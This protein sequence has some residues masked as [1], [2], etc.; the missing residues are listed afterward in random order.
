MSDF[1][2]TALTIIGG[3]VVVGFAFKLLSGLLAILIP[4]I[5]IAAVAGGVVFILK[6][7]SSRRELNRY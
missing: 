2:K 5:V 4:I 1:L 3:I 6:G 7:G